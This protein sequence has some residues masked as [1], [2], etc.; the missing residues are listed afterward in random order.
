M[1]VK[2]YHPL[3]V[4]RRGGCGVSR[5]PYG[6]AR[7]SRLGPLW[8][9]DEAARDPA[10]GLPLGGAGSGTVKSLPCTTLTRL[11][12][13]ARTKSHP[14]CMESRLRSDGWDQVPPTP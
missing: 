11:A 8:L 12:E 4:P 13:G 7:A 1:A 6:A 9:W 14:H 2:A 10:G 3:F 5:G